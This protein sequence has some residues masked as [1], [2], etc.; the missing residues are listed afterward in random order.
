MDIPP[1]LIVSAERLALSGSTS[2]IHRRF[3]A[4]RYVRLRRGYYV[5]TSVWVEATP[6]E[7]FEWSAAAVGLAFEQ[8]VFHGESAAV[9]LGIPTLRTPPLVE[10]ATDSERITGR[11]PPTFTVHGQSALAE[12]ARNL[13]NYPMRYVLRR[14]VDAVVSGQF[15]CTS[16]VQ[17]AVDVMISSSFSKALVVAEGVAR[18]L[19]DQG[20]LDRDAC[21]ADHP[22]IAEEL[23]GISSEATGLRT[24]R[25]ARLAQAK[26]E[27]VGES[28]SKAAFELLDFEQPMQQHTIY[29][30][31]QFV[32]RTDFWWPQQNV[33][34]E[35]DGKAKYV[36][37][38]LRGRLT[39]EEIVYQEKLREDRIRSLAFAFVRWSWAD[40]EQPGLLRQKLL[41][42]GLRPRS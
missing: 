6:A 3:R 21:L 29:D 25:L 19:V 7:R 5:E 11:R 40:L 26:S 30:S 10:L 42:A 22:G 12:Q 41:R 23:D 28:F 32:A 37:K 24:H 38:E 17:T 1:Q 9:V 33:V 15:A 8:P 34:G 4:G 35:F 36:D 27:S 18:A 31:G 14:D 20:T 16:L 2:S 39:A 13:G